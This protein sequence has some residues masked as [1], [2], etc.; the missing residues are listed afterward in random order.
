MT[1]ILWTD[2]SAN[3]NPGPGGYAVLENGEP[4]RVGNERRSSNIR[5]EGAALIAAMEYAGKEGCK[6]YTD[7]QFW[8]NV[9]TKWAS[10]WQRRGWKKTGG[11]IKNLE[12]VQAAYKLYTENPVELHW[13]RGHVGTELNEKADQT[14]NAARRG[15]TLP[16]ESII[17]KELLK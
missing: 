5:M 11:P 1:R 6:I 14:A 8:V 10:G 3:P 9:L 15:Y 12:L 7:S 17:L 13:T 4:V 2:G 16:E